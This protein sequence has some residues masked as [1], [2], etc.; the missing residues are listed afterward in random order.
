MRSNRYSFR[1]S[2]RL[3]MSKQRSSSTA[4]GIQ[5]SPQAL[6]LPGRP[7]STRRGRIPFFAKSRPAAQPAGPAP[8]IRADRGPFGVNKT[9]NSWP[10]QEG[11][12]HGLVPTHTPYHT[13]VSNRFSLFGQDNGPRRSG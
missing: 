10:S 9:R 12:R 8:I 3:S 11:G 1:S 5:P 4:D 7:F 6:S 13:V 2:L